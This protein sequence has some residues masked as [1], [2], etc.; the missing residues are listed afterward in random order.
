[1]RLALPSSSLLVALCLAG[2]DEKKPA[3]AATDKPAPSAPAAPASIAPAASSAAPQPLASSSAAPDADQPPCTIDRKFTID[4]GARLDAGLTEAEIDDDRSAIGYAVGEGEPRVAVVDHATGKISKPE[5]QWDKLKGEAKK[6][7]MVRK[8]LRVTPLSVSGGKARVGVDLVDTSKKEKNAARYLRCGPADQEPIVHDD[9]PLQFFDPTE[10]DVAKAGTDAATLDVR[11]CRTFSDGP[12]AWVAATIVKR[13]GADNHDLL[14]EWVIDTMPGKSAPRDAVLDKRVLKPKAD[15]KYPV[16]DHFYTTVSVRAKTGGYFLASRD[17]G[18]LV[19][20]HRTATLD[21]LAPPVTWRLDAA[22]RPIPQLAVEGDRVFLFVTETGK[23]DLFASTWKS[24]DKPIRPE[25]IAID[26]PAPKEGQRDSVSAS[27]GPD[28][29]IFVAFT[30]GDQ[31]D[32]AKLIVVGPDLK[33][34]TKSVT[35]LSPKEVHADEVRVVAL[36]KKRAMVS[37][38][39]ANGQ[40]TGAVVTCAY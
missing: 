14:A 6:D 23:H 26:D 38:I 25:P 15:K 34:K 21:K 5:V 35:T 31:H 4:T 10:D 16:L 36:S 11:D 39:E 3:P 9:S 33:H 7:G 20:A 27:N 28:D 8:V 13:A 1:M 18:S 29:A 30:D 12:D 22:P 17:Q 37:W 24:S 32:M 2:C 19:L 40:L